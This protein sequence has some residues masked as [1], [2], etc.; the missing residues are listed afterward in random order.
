MTESSPDQRPRDLLTA[1]LPHIP[2]DGWSRAALLA[3]AKDLGLAGADVTAAFPRGPIDA[4][5]LFSVCADE[6]MV[7]AVAAH[8]GEEMRL[9]DRI[10]AGIRAR[11]EDQ[12]DLKDQVRKGMGVLALPQNAPIGAKCLYDTV[13]LLWYAAGDTSTD[14]NFYTKRALLS[15][16]YGATLLFWLSDGS[17]GHARTWEFLGRRIDDALRVPKAALQGLEALRHLPT[18]IPNPLRLARSLGLFRHLS[19]HTRRSVRF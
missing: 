19:F 7:A 4:I 10:I 11:L 1:A 15:G 5:R 2:F 6:R 14:H 9:R 12:A 17:A 18:A 3:G 16:V 13:N 8:A